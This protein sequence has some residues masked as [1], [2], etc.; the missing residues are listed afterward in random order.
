ME[1][2][3]RSSFFVISSFEHPLIIKMANS[4]T[5]K[6]KCLI[7]DTLGIKYNLYI[8]VRI[9]LVEV[10]EEVEAGP[11]YRNAPSASDRCSITVSDGTVLVYLAYLGPVFVSHNSV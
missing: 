3:G 11:G 5:A 9:K 10:E 1:Y 6:A 2:S 7:G 8:G 4:K